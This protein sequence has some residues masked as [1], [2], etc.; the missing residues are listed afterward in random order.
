MA[1]SG[2]ELAAD[3][4]L[5]RKL[6]WLTLFRLVT[7]TVLL[8]GTAIVGWDGTPD[9]VRVTQPLY[10]L[11]VATYLASAAIAFALRLWRGL[12]AVGFAQVALDVG[13]AGVVVALT[14]GADSVFVFLYLLVDQRYTPQ[15]CVEAGFA[16]AFVRAVVERVRVLGSERSDRRRRDAGLRSDLPDAHNNFARRSVR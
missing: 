4:V 10:A 15:E 1:G 12:V 7:I 3:A 5:H 8:G 16:E 9:A 11:V 14:G 6:V 13:L 2:L